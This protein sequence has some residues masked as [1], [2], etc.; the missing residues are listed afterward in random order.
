MAGFA[1]SLGGP[2]R[3]LADEPRVREALLLSLLLMFLLHHLQTD[4]ERLVRDAESYLDER[5]LQSLRAA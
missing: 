4:Q 3:V 5:L 2:D 1:S